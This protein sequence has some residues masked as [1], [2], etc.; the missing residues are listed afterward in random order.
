[1][2]CDGGFVSLCSFLGADLVSW[3]GRA[4]VVVALVIVLVSQSIDLFDVFVV[5]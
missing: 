2:G 5:G 1:V 3:R 4:Y